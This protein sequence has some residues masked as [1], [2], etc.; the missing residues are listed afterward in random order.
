MAGDRGQTA[1]EMSGAS[2]GRA[3]RA[4]RQFKHSEVAAY[5]GHFAGSDGAT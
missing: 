5:K 2:P 3:T 1:R 4:V